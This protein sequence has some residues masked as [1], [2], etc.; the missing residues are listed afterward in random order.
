MKI[1]E[2]ATAAGVDAQTLRYYEK[3]RLLP[4]P[5]REANGYRS[6]PPQALERVRFI[7]HCRELDMSL[8]E[9][10]RILHLSE[11]PEADCDDINAILDKHLE[12]VRTRQAM[13]MQLEQQLQALRA[14]CHVHNRAADCG[15]LKDLMRAAADSNCSCHP[16]R[17]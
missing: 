2:L 1:G 6:Y 4:A 10:A 7:R 17:K 15:I 5:I 9:V 11:T 13:L 14:Q 16:L 12:Q 8:E 3:I